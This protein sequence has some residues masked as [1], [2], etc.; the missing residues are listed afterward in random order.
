LN[1]WSGLNGSSWRWLRI[2]RRINV[3]VIVITVEL[4][5]TRTIAEETA[6]IP[7]VF[8]P[9]VNLLGCFPCIPHPL[10]VRARKGCSNSEA[11]YVIPVEN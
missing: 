6:A 8:K 9:I 7:T 11:I 10:D 4:S 3:F 2:D 1:G 5:F